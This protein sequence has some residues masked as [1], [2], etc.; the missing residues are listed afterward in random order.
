MD[1]E[2]FRA[3]AEEVSGQD[4]STL[5]AQLLHTTELYDYAVG[6]VKARRTTGREGTP[7]WVTR[8]EVKRKAPGQIPVDVAVIAEGDTALGADRRTGDE[9]VGGD[10]DPN[11]A[12]RGAA[13]TRVSMPT[14][15]T[16]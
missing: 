15:G 2:A 5:F 12:T 6:R 10:R 1:E 11:P 3:V 13:W 7:G 9:R 4:L 8:V 16:C 14:T